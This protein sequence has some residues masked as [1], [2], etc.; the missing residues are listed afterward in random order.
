[1]TAGFLVIGAIIIAVGRYREKRAAA[2]NDSDS[3]PAVDAVPV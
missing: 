1:M 2:R 3:A